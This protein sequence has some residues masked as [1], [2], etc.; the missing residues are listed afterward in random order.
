MSGVLNELIRA[1]INVMEEK[2]RSL[3][4][5]YRRKQITKSA[6]N[7]SSL[8]EMVGVNPFELLGWGKSLVCYNVRMK[9]AW[10]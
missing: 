6:I 7:K 8:S 10:A 1:L 5:F 4:Y 3:D 2:D 9:Y